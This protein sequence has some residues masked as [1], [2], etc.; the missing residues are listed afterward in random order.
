MRCCHNKKGNR[1]VCGIVARSRRYPIVG[2]DRIIEVDIQG[3][4]LKV[5]TAVEH[6][7][8]MDQE[9]WLRINSNR[10]HVFNKKDSLA[11]C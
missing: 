5:I 7:V 11:V 8:E 3:H 6:N 1:R 4:H 2:K 9:V 10:M